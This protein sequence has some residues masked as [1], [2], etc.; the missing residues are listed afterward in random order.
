M[1]ALP[2]E[3]QPP[4]RWVS[5]P[6]LAS[7]LALDPV[8]LR[9]WIWTRHVEAREVTPGVYEINIY[10]LPEDDKRHYFTL[11]PHLN[12]AEAIADAAPR[13]TNARLESVRSRADDRVDAVLSYRAARAARLPHE[14]FAA[15]ESAWIDHYRLTH[16]ELK[17]SLRSVKNWDADFAKFGIDGLVDGNDGSKKLGST[18][19][20]EARQLIRDLYLQKRQPKL[21]LV[22]NHV[23]DEAAV[24]GWGAMPSYRA[25]RKYVKSIPRM[26]RMLGRES[27]D[28]PRDV[29]PYV[30]R[31]PTS[32][33]VYHTIQGDHRWLD[34]AVSCDDHT[35]RRCYFGGAGRRVLGHRPVWTAWIDTRSRYIVGHELSLDAPDTRR[36]LRSVGRITLEHG[37]APRYYVDNG[38]DFVAAFGD[39]SPL[40]KSSYK[41]Q[42]PTKLA[43]RLA[44]LG[45]EVVYALP[46]NPQGKGMIESA[47]RS[48]D[49][50]FDQQ[51][52][53][54]NEFQDRDAL[55]KVS[56]IAYRLQLAVERYNMTPHGGLGMNGR[57]P[58][59]VFSDESL[60]APRRDADP[61]TFAL[62]FFE[63]AGTRIVG[64]LGVRIDGRTYRLSALEKQFEYFGERVEVRI[65]PDDPRRVVLFDRK[66]GGYICDAVLDEVLATYDTRDDV[67][68][69][70]IAR[71]FRDIYALR[72]MAARAI[73][74]D[75][76][77]RLAEHARVMLA[78]YEHLTSGTSDKAAPSSTAEA[79]AFMTQLHDVTR[80]REGKLRDLPEAEWRLFSEAEFL[81]RASYLD[82][83]P[84]HLAPSPED[85]AEDSDVRTNIVRLDHGLC[86]LCGEHVGRSRV[87]CTNHEIETGF[88]EPK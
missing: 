14:T 34:I 6:Q 57:T 73:S 74:G 65:W 82:A 16:P 79:F 46:G 26:A 84:N 68:K 54:P 59:E 36:T 52:P 62:L 51:F 29:L 23:C 32:V 24:R 61:A 69:W 55:P 86:E 50:M 20:E 19:P 71:T 5:V 63:P 7:D 38:S 28:S 21:R 1:T 30:R 41:H 8:A 47:F 78:Y 18:I 2:Q 13:Y 88:T 4:R 44:A 42:K 40:S 64:R 49:A 9:Q 45:S 58:H 33:P 53:I 15:V 60:R 39:H 48:F 31:D 12:P 80:D 35:C 3:P 11:Y 70:L 67:T 72:R 10:S 85:T 75:V 22:Y 77:A 87:L 81:A 56:E 43:P 17:V 27:A 25:F 83:N 37:V 66:T 76:K